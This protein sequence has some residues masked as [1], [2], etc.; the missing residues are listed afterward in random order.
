MLIVVLQVNLI[1][2]KCFTVPMSMH[3]S[4]TLDILVQVSR[5]AA[6]DHAGGNAKSICHKA[7]PSSE[8]H[9]GYQS[10][11]IW[12][13]RT[14]G[15]AHV[16]ANRQLAIGTDL[17]D[18]RFRMIWCMRYDATMAPYR[19]CTMMVHMLRGAAYTGWCPARTV[20]F[21]VNNTCTICSHLGL[22]RSLSCRVQNCPQS[23]LCLFLPGWQVRGRTVPPFCHND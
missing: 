20:C 8:E 4:R 19:M 3:L 13:Y 15:V 11:L 7:V 18:I 12:Q 16:L 14:S 9:S 10:W 21:S 17:Q 22:I 6:L 23:H 2:D 5:C 1:L